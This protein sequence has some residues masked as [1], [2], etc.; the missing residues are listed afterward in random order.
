M[1]LASG[2]PWALAPTGF[3]FGLV[4]SATTGTFVKPLSLVLSLALAL[5]SV[6]LVLKIDLDRA[7]AVGRIRLR[8]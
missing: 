2:R 8:L 4:S 3:Q 1:P 5:G 6:R 7:S